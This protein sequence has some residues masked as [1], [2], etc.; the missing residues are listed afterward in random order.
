MY[1]EVIA[2][3]QKPS[4]N[5]TM[6]KRRPLTPAKR[7][8]HTHRHTQLSLFLPRR[9][10]NKTRQN[11][12]REGGREE[13]GEGGA[14]SSSKLHKRKKRERGHRYPPYSFL[15]LPNF[16]LSLSLCRPLF[17]TEMN[18]MQAAVTYTHT[19][20][21]HTELQQTRGVACSTKKSLKNL[22][23]HHHHHAAAAAAAQANP[24]AASSTSI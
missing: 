1:V 12:C 23:H 14:S 15:L 7:G 17:S 10:G 6:R 9:D 21:V 11:R 18:S 20:T 16:S 24:T 8:S 5:L 3:K 22:Q 13:G 19:H 4:L 2:Q